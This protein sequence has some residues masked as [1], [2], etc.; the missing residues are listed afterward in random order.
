MTSPVI[1]IP[2]S[3][4]KSSDLTVSGIGHSVIRGLVTN[5]LMVRREPCDL[6]ARIT[7]HKHV[8]AKKWRSWLEPY[9][10]HSSF[11]MLSRTNSVISDCQGEQFRACSSP[12]RKR[13]VTR[14]PAVR[15]RSGDFFR[16]TDVEKILLLD[17]LPGR[18]MFGRLQSIRRWAGGLSSLAP[19]PSRPSPWLRTSR[20][21]MFCPGRQGR[22]DQPAFP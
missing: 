17:R 18:V 9:S 15:S 11:Q 21:N 22:R 12:S 6:K 3:L 8:P 10:D 20:P 1:S 14:K 19:I 4:G 13:L 2:T 5:R 7:I 16:Y